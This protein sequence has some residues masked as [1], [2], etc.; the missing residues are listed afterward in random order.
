MLTAMINFTV[1]NRTASRTLVYHGEYRPWILQTYFSRILLPQS[2]SFH[3]GRPGKEPL[4]VVDSN[5][6][7][8]DVTIV[9]EL[10]VKYNIIVEYTNVIK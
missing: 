8:M 7:A 4:D 5:L 3:R 1:Y 2:D 10:Y 6:K 9:F